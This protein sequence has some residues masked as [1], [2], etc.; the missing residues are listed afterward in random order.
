G[1]SDTILPFSR[2]YGAFI[3][4]ATPAMMCSFVMNN[5]LRFEGHASLAMIG[6]VLG[7]FLNVIG[8]W[9]TISILDMGI[10]GVGLSTMVSNYVSMLLLLSMF[11][12][13]KTQTRLQIKRIFRKNVPVSDSQS[14]DMP[15]R[16]TVGHILINIIFIGL[17]SLARQGL[18]SAST[19][20]MNW[21]ARPYGDAAIAAMSI[22]MRIS[23]MLFAVGLGIG[24]GFQPVSGFNY[25]AQK[26]DRVRKAALFTWGFST[27]VMGISAVVCWLIGENLIAL[28][29][30]DEEVFIIGTPALHYQ[31]MSIILVPISF[32]GNM[33]FQSIGKG[34]R[35]LFLSCL[36]SGLC[37]IPVLLI[38]VP[39]LGLLGIQIAQ[40]IADVLAAVITL[41]FF[42]SF[43]RTL[44]KEETPAT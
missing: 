24:Q 10:E 40:P 18:T 29:S 41:P 21:M 44:K 35:A 39:M 11:L 30:S 7:G 15:D 22:V 25:G 28:F 32:I 37:Y 31:L 42:L 20:V 2:V 3:L 16:S 13:K 34:G 27:V 26:Y 19:M 14:T 12:R 9:V 8:D 1:S 6:L 5:I 17:P 33:L 38:L 23:F 4:C 43:L 36:R